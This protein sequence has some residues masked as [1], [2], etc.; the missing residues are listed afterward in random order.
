MIS[1]KDSA[2]SLLLILSQQRQSPQR[3]P[4]LFIAASLL[5]R[6]R[7]S[8]RTPV[9]RWGT[10]RSSSGGKPTLLSY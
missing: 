6:R 8:C 1:I 7:V 4:V 2:F 3:E 9:L 5:L 10:K